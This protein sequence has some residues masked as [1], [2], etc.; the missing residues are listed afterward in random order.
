MMDGRI[1]IKSELGK[2]STFTFTFRARRGEGEDEDRVGFIPGR[3]WGSVRVLAVDD[4]PETL[5]YF[6]EILTRLGVTCDT[7]GG[8][9][10]ALAA[11]AKN[12]DYDIYFLDWN[13]PDMNGAE[14]AERIR[15]GH[16]ESVITVISSADWSSIEKDAKCAGVDK[17]LQ[18]PVF[19]STLA[20]F[21]G[22]CLGVKGMLPER[23]ALPEKG[24]V[25]S[26]AG[27]RILLAEDVE[28]NR[29]IAISLLEPT[30][31]SIVCAENGN[32][33]VRLFAEN[34]TGYDMIFMDVQMP[35]MDG[36]EA[37]RRIRAMQDVP[38]AATIPIVAM[39]ANVFKE[40]V[41][42]CLAAGMN[43]HL[44]KPINLDELL[45]KLR[46]YIKKPA[47]P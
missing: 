41:E 14:L 2:G 23:G 1:W 20:D 17:F 27:C 43:A 38:H 18:K 19:P 13:M 34:P 10:D 16:P 4:D 33:V 26:W 15:S 22:E 28:I 11:I 24:K 29:E 44:G 6:L 8:G 12:G 46:F 45:D 7:T 36:L 42:H 47:Q 37:T 31:I 35:G 3:E 40:D 9:E 30:E 5:E 25:Q 32:E 39:T 21:I